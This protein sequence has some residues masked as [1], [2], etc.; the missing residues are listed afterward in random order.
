MTEPAVIR[1]LPVQG[2]RPTLDDRVDLRDLLPG[3]HPVRDT[4][5]Y[6]DDR[7]DF[8]GYPFV[9]QTVRY[10]DFTAVPARWR[11]AV[12]DWTLMRLNPDLA[13]TGASK[14]DTNDVM[15]GAAAAERPIKVP[16]ALAYINC[17]AASLTIVDQMSREALN[18]TDWNEFVARMR[19]EFPDAAAVTLAS[20]ARPLLSLWSYRGVLGLPGNLFGGRPFTG[21]TVEQM[22]K[23]PERGLNAARPDA[24]T[25]GPLLGLALWILDHCAEDIL[26][27]L[28]VLAAVPDNTHLDREGQIDK[29]LEVLDAYERTGLPVPAMPILGRDTLAPAWSTFVK[30][31]GCARRELPSPKGRATHRFTDLCEQLGISEAQDGF[32]LPV[33]VVPDRDGALTPWID[34]LRPTKHHLG[35]DFWSC[36]LAYACALIISMLTTVRERELAAL[37]HDCIR[38]SKYDRGDTEVPVTRMHGYLVKNRTDPIPATWVVADDVVRAVQVVHRLKAALRLEPLLHPQTGREILMHPGLGRAR[39]TVKLTDTL[40]LD[41]MWL[42][43]L[44]QAGDH[45]AGRGL[46][47]NLP[48][49]PEFLPHRVL[50]ITGIEAYASQAWGDA[51]AAAQAHWSSRTVAHGYLGHLP[52]SVYL[53]DPDAIEEA[54]QRDRAWSLLDVATR[55]VDDPGAVTGNGADRV[56]DLLRD[57]GATELATGPITPRQ[58]T[59]LARRTEQVFVGEHTICVFGPGG[60]CGSSTEAEWKL[61][62]PG[63][64]RNSGMTR[65]QRARLELRRRGLVGRDGVFQRARRKLEDD[66]PTLAEEFA[67]LDDTALRDLVLADLPGRFATA[68]QESADDQQP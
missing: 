65:A 59:V 15:A 1:P 62:R 24:E 45:L 35:L 25:C 51:L 49:L 32:K 50:R 5:R 22:F 44:R 53:A 43:W 27:R 23:V 36:T 66:N 68:A 12:K 64:C 10:L 26:S 6:Q 46:L 57:T 54:T 58:L 8:T 29:V 67:N 9:N 17:F 60:L 33:A 7:W 31:A 41:G 19:L 38:S 39:G 4:I 47:P 20:Y 30:L 2:A 48:E 3:G 13:R 42:T 28:E 63:A 61:C 52:R 55:L 34:A 18:E 14:L 56:R 21:R 40:G 11:N 37:P 16:S